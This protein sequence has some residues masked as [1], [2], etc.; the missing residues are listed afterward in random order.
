MKIESKRLIIKPLTTNQV[1]KYLKNDNSL[2][3][4]LGLNYSLRVIT[5]ELKEAIEK[6]IYPNT[7]KNKENYLFY[8]LWSIILKEQNEIVGDL[9][10]YG[11]PDNDGKIEIAYGTYE[12]YVGKG[13]MTEAVKHIILWAKNQDNVKS[14]VARTNIENIASF[15][16]L[17]KNGFI[18][19]S[20]SKYFYFWELIIDASK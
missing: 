8:T 20:E 12:K 3:K 2:E 17:E 19:Q 6:S 1:S 5:K 15:R 16:I 18:K 10:F 7:L 4:E 13:I 9:C 11:M 14:I